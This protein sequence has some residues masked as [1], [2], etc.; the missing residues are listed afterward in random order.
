MSK[1]GSSV[2]RWM[3]RSVSFDDDKNMQESLDQGYE[4]FAIITRF[5]K[6][7]ILD[8]NKPSSNGLVPV[9]LMF[10]KQSYMIEL[11]E[12]GKEKNVVSIFK[13]DQGQPSETNKEPA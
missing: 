3:L 10:F 8:P 6:E 7:S 12:N 1:K 9:N 2:K 4:P 13:K 5:I 11:D